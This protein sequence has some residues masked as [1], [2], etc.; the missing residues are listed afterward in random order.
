MYMTSLKEN[1]LFAHLYLDTFC[2]ED[3]S[4]K[5]L[6]SYMNVCCRGEEVTISTLPSWNKVQRDHIAFL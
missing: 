4:A 6:R 5:Y 1:T 3:G 2:L